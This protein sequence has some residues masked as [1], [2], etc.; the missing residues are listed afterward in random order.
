M[1]PSRTSGEMAQTPPSTIRLPPP[2]TTSELYSNSALSTDSPASTSG[3]PFTAHSTSPTNHRYGQASVP[4]PKSGGR[5]SVRASFS[6]V[7]KNRR[8]SRAGTVGIDEMVQDEDSAPKL[9]TLVPGIRPAYSTPLP[10]L[11]MIVLCIV[12]PTR[13]SVD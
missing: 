7:G 10:T 5:R 9:P 8:V 11:P 12:G 3:S 4:L 6:T 2:P 1:I 13:V